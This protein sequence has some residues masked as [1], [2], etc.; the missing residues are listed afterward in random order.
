MRY[1]KLK[2]R[3]DKLKMIYSEMSDSN[4]YLLQ[5]NKVMKEDVKKLIITLIKEDIYITSEIIE[6]YIKSDYLPFF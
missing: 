5:K 3:Y 2:V 4:T 6:R 1:S